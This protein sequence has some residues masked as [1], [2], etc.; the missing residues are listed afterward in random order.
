MPG[1]DYTIFIG[2]HVVIIV[3][4]SIGDCSSIMAR[5]SFHWLLVECVRRWLM[6]LIW[7]RKCLPQFVHFGPEGGR[8]EELIALAFCAAHSLSA[9]A[10]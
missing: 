9:K 10:L 6:K 1:S 2:N 7:T 5:T 3:R 8:A 4:P